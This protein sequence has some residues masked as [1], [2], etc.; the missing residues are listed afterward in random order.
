MTLSP[1]PQVNGR[2]NTNNLTQANLINLSRIVEDVETKSI[3][4]SIKTTTCAVSSHKGGK[5]KINQYIISTFA[6]RGKFSKVHQCV[7]EIDG[8]KYAMKIIKKNKINH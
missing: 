7:N 1:I 3:G 8:K 6:G 4:R 5:K 2:Q